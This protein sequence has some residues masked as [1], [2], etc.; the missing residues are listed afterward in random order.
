MADANITLLSVQTTR[1]FLTARK[2]EQEERTFT[3]RSASFK[4][5]WDLDAKLLEVYKNEE[6]MLIK[7]QSIGGQTGVKATELK[8]SLDLQRQRLTEVYGKELEI[9]KRIISDQQEFERNRMQLAEISRKKDSI[10]NIVTALVDSKETRTVNFKLRYNVKDAGWFPTYDV[11]VNEVNEPLSVLMNANVYQRSGETWKNI[12]LLLSTGNP[13]DNAT[14]SDLQP[15][16]L[17]FYDPSVSVR[18]Q[19]VQGTYTGRITD[20]KNQPV[21][22]ATVMTKGTRAATSTDENGFFKIQTTSMASSLVISAVGY[23]AKEVRG[24]AG[25]FYHRT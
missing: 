16:M 25:I 12:S 14:P 6:T 22:G 1:D 3:E 2:M 5:K 15:W 17:G 13:N 9:Q 4:D 18:G 20:E 8:E 7:N 10:S 23:Q 19:S 11:R 24:Q 21:S